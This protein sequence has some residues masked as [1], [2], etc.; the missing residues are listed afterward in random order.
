[1]L[2][3]LAA[4]TIP[5]AA[6]SVQRDYLADLPT[7][8]STGPEVQNDEVVFATLDPVGIPTDAV[9]ISRV[10]SRGGPERDI[11]DPASVEEVEYLSQD[12][13][14][15]TSGE[16]QILTIG[17]EGTRTVVTR[18]NFDKSLPVTVNARYELNG[19][20]TP[21]TAVNGESGELSIRYRITN[22]VASVEEIQ[23]GNAFGATTTA[24]QP[25]LAPFAGIVSTTLPKDA[26]LV[27]AP[28]A[29]VGSNKAGQVVLTW[30]IVLFPPLG[31]NEQ[32]LSFTLRSETVELPET[33]FSLAPVTAE[34]DP[35]IGFAAT[36]LSDTANGQSS[37]VAGLTALDQQAQALATGAAAISNGSQ[38]LIAGAQGLASGSAALA[39]G[40][41]QLADGAGQQAQ[42]Q[43]ALAQA[44]TAGAAG[45]DE[46]VGG[47]QALAAGLNALIGALSQLTA[48]DAFPALVASA[49]ALTDGA[50]LAADNFGSSADPVI[51]VPPPSC[52]PNVDPACTPTIYQSVR[53]VRDALIVYRDQMQLLVT[54]IESLVAPVQDILAT[55]TELLNQATENLADAEQLYDDFCPGPAFCDPLQALIDGLSQALA[56]AAEIADDIS[57]LNP[58][59]AEI[60]AQLEAAGGP[61]AALVGSLTDLIDGL[62]ELLVGMDVFAAGL[63]SSD[64]AQPG[65]ANGLEALTSA[66]AA[67]NR[68]LDELVAQSGAAQQGMAGLVAGTEILADGVGQA[69]DGASL[70]SDTSDALAAGSAG[71][72]DGARQLADGAGQAAGAAGQ[73]AAGTSQ[74]AQGAQAFQE[75]GT[76]AA[77]DGFAQ[78]A[79]QA[80]LADAWFRAAENKAGSALPYGAP[81][82]AVG[83]SAYILTMAPSDSGGTIPWRT[84]SIGLLVLSAIGGIG[85]LFWRRGDSYE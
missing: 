48:P 22:T 3:V 79:D 44:L 25:V 9:L 76:A 18:S 61:E 43:A 21:P 63:R 29:V 51:P 53:F 19:Q 57:Q 46:L 4:V 58:V 69:A 7:V 15:E 68:G 65:L 13:A 80:A 52:D 11:V 75:Q 82:N 55:A 83:T 24:Q 47:S 28:T 30:N 12:G 85:Y 49:Q 33:V 70:L 36:L 56:D 84:L 10:T 26:Q 41:G 17:G 2:V 8:G 23:F 38:A 40:V 20:N 72:A 59:L 77:V 66:L 37:A 6:A 50:N 16:G 39:S 32:E 34:Q 78:G 60:I 73:F 81:E 1:M 62:N 45:A 5:G 35:A 14:P 67:V 54:A 64:P 27:A 31:S 71:A 42:G 74:L